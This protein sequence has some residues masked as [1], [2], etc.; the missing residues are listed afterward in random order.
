MNCMLDL[1]PLTVKQQKMV[2]EVAAAVYRPCCNNSTLFSDCNH[3][4]AML[5]LLE[6]M[7]SQGVTID[8]MFEAAKYVNAFWFPEQT[9]DVAIYL[10]TNYWV[11]FA[12]AAPRQVVRRELP[13]ASGF[14]MVHQSLV[15]SGEVKQAQSQGVG[16]SNCCVNKKHLV[17][18]AYFSN[19]LTIFSI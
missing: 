17:R 16:C 5:S 10:Q 8:Q 13:S 12:H 15:R 18:G 11:D 14:K 7:A 6:L 4:M 1:I 19:F 3:G 9:L 2:E